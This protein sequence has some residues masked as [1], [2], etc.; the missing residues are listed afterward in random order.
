[1]KTTINERPNLHITLPNNII[2]AVETVALEYFG[3]KQYKGHTV[4]SKQDFFHQI[5]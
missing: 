2:T 1:M 3:G 4:F 5:E